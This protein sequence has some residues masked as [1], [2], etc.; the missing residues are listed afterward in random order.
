MGAGAARAKYL[1][2]LKDLKTLVGFL[3]GHYSSNY[4]ME[5]IRMVASVK[6]NQCEEKEQTTLHII[7]GALGANMGV[8]APLS[9]TIS[10][11]IE[12]KGAEAKSV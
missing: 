12:H 2:F 4:H 1:L 11:E 7:S 9:A 5:Q 6:R 8:T 10:S 3:M